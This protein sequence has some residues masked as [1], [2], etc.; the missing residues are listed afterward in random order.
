MNCKKFTIS[1][2]TN[3]K[4]SNIKKPKFSRFFAQIIILV[5][6]ILDIKLIVDFEIK[7]IEKNINNF[8]LLLA[9]FLAKS[10]LK[11]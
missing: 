5:N 1:L 7:N 9:F 11:N 8:N 4:L 3:I 6:I 10:K 2:S